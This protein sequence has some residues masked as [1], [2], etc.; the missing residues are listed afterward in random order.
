MKKLIKTVFKKMRRILSPPTK[1]EN[2]N[3]SK[4]RPFRIIKKWF[5]KYVRCRLFGSIITT[6]IK[7]QIIR[8]VIYDIRMKLVNSQIIYVI[9]GEHSQQLVLSWLDGTPL[10]YIDKNGIKIL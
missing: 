3:K 6:C 9:K 5:N 2:I 1:P 7:D 10:S 8:I 4:H